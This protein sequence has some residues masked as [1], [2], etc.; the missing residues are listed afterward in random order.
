VATAI[1]RRPLLA[2]LAVV[3]PGLLAGLSDDDAGGIATYSI[4]GADRGYTLLW[5]LVAATGMLVL[6]HMIGL[7]LGAVTGQ[8]LAGL[9]RERYGVR[10]AV[11]ALTSLVIANVGTTCAELAGVAAASDLMGVPRWVSVPV[12]AVG[13]T[14]LVIGAQFH[15]VEHVLLALSAMLAAYVASGLLADPSWTEA[16]RGSLVP[17][18][19]W[20]AATILL[21]TATIGTTIAPWGLS[22]IQS[23]AVDKRITASDLRYARVDVISGAVLTGVIGFFVVIAC[24]ATLHA[25]DR[26]VDDAADAAQALAPL[27]GEW[28]SRLFAAGLLG[29]SLLA[30]AIVPLS[31]AYSVAE[32]LGSESRL[33]DRLGEAR[34]FYGTYVAVMAGSCAIVL[35]PGVPLIG[36][37]FLT[38][39]LNA[40]MLVPLL[41]FV[42]RLAGDPAVMGGQRTRP[43]ASAAAWLTVAVVGL[44]VLALALVS[45]R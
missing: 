34:L 40:V 15:R 21:V 23:Y 16:A 24:A 41:V 14:W 35:V 1:S 10:A 38:Q 43:A 20:D 36:V 37:L 6:F 31:T 12:A 30:A 5:V 2:V 29:A 19:S 7:R 22:F 9:I 18:M 28:A 27:A 32:T 25:E 26:H 33:D 39:A 17:S 3:G 44:C 13:V 11:L 8:G 4:L 45:A 42:T